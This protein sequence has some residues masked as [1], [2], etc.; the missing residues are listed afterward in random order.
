MGKRNNKGTY[1]S[2]ILGMIGAKTGDRFYCK[3]CGYVALDTNGEEAI[4]FSTLNSKE[5]KCFTTRL[6]GRMFETGEVMVFPSKTM[7]DW[8]KLKISKGDV[9]VSEE[10]NYAI[11]EKWARNSGY[12]RMLVRH[13]ITPKGVYSDNGIWLTECSS[14]LEIDGLCERAYLEKLQ[15]E[16]GILNPETLELKKRD[17]FQEGDILHRGDKGNGFIFI[18]KGMD[19]LNGYVNRYVN[20]DE[21]SNEILYKKDG[22]MQLSGK[23]IRK[24]DEGEVRKLFDV[25]YGKGLTWNEKELCLY[26][27]PCS[28]DKD[29]QQP[30]TKVLC[31]SQDNPQWMPQHLLRFDDNFFYSMEGGKFEEC[32]PYV[33]N[34]GFAFRTCS[35]LPFKQENL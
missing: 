3:V 22:H 32:I 9:V 35:M 2:E 12:S 15:N 17:N 10:G 5:K 21:A 31:R 16:H 13:I 29:E 30:F 26:T 20:Y 6:D 1:V 23:P 27:F 33:G 28:F 19:Y 8:E 18:L 11:F 25:L 4:V 7:Q 14:R 34:E 24:A